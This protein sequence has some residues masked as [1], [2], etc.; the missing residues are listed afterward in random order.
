[1]YGV[2][3][4]SINTG[5]DSELQYVFST[6]LKII[7][8]QPAFVADT[9]SL[10]R[11]VNSQNVQRW[12]IE[13]EIVPE[14]NSANFLIH[15]VKHG[16]TDVFRLRMPQVFTFTKIKQ[17]LALT[18][19]ST[20]FIG[21]SVIDITGVGSVDLTGQF[22]NFQGD[23]KVYLI[24]SK[25]DMGAGIEIE[26]PLL[27]SIASN[28][29]ITYGDKTTMLARYDTDNQAGITYT[30]GILSSPGVVRYVEAL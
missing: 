16:F 3:K 8:N 4:S 2:L 22:I 6:P 9:M 27:K 29:T 26:P 19:T 15:S 24:T 14:N 7:S 30:D 28:S 21:S 23:S 12:E 17:N 5:V 25:G 1:M 11:K 13:T 18:L 20:K 10:K